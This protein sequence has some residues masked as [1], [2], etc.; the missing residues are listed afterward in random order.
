MNKG[1]ITNPTPP[2][3][4]PAHPDVEAL[5]QAVASMRGHSPFAF[6]GTIYEVAC[7]E[8]GF[9][10]SLQDAASLLETSPE[11]HVEPAP[12]LAECK[13]RSSLWHPHQHRNAQSE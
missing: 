13:I 10:G 3:E 7:Q 11:A 1:R 9:Q 12:R 5:H 8:F 2:P 4:R 6:L